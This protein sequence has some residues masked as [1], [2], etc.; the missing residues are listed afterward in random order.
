MDEGSR[1]HDIGHDGGHPGRLSSAGTPN[2]GGS[3]PGSAV[4]LGRQPS[5]GGTASPKRVDSPS[6][7]PLPP[8][9]SPF[10]RAPSNQALYASD[11][12]IA[13]TVDMSD[14]PPGV[15]TPRRADSLAR[16]FF[17]LLPGQASPV[18]STECGSQAN[19]ASAPMAYSLS[20]RSTAKAGSG[21]VATPPPTPRSGDMSPTPAATVTAPPGLGSRL[22]G[23]LGCLLEAAGTSGSSIAELAA[24]SS[25]ALAPSGRSG[26]SR[27]GSFASLASC[28]SSA[29]NFGS[30]CGGAE[31]EE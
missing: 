25:G 18:D 22:A 8:L 27:E 2:S 31:G 3:Q 1:L 13:A 4:A 12:E 30:P 9:S 23:L 17:S 21:A 20:E 11:S 10:R 15:H 6:R 14:L 29:A 16:A 19:Q 26:P 28:G 24:A 5:A 7:Q